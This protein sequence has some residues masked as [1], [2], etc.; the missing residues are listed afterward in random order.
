MFNKRIY[1]ISGFDPRGARFYHRL[2]REEAKKS[3]TLSGAEIDTGRRKV[4][5]KLITQWQVDSVWDGKSYI[6]DYRFMTWDDVMKRYWISNVWILILKSIPMFFNHIKIRLF[7]KFKKAGRGPYF[8]SI[9]PLVFGSLSLLISALVG[10]LIYILV[11]WVFSQVWLATFLSLLSGYFLVR[12]AVRLGES[13]NVWWILQ[14]YFFISQWSENPLP[15]LEER[16]RQFAERIIQDQAENPLDEIILVGHCVGSMLAVEVMANIANLKH[17]GL[18]GKLSVLTLGQCIPYL[19][20]APKAAHF[21]KSL[22]QF[23]N[24]KRFHWFDMGAKADPLCFQEVNPALA[25]GITLEDKNV[26][27]RF[28]VRPYN[29]FSAEKYNAL[30][31]NKLRMHFQYLMAADIKTDY[32]YFEIVTGPFAKIQTYKKL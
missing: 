30:K 14:T 1:Y 19:S 2:F 31:K 15:E 28:I 12:Y 20:Y 21:R 23:A 5:D 29:M 32:D 4:L 11:F 26:P 6:T 17:N 18:V 16:M 24:N 3:T 9:Y 8:C 7:P 27:Y 22:Q 25:E 10:S 13:L